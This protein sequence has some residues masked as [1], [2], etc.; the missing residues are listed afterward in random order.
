MIDPNEELSDRFLERILIGYVVCMM[1]FC[2]IGVGG[3]AWLV[4]RA[5]FA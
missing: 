1:I 3:V 2:F 5:V 4:M